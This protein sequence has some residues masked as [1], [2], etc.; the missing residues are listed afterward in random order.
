[1]IKVKITRNGQL[2]R[3]FSLRGHS[4]YLPRG[5]DIVCSAVSALSQTAVLALAQ[6]AGV[7]PVWTR[8]DGVLECKLPDDLDCLQTEASQTVLATI[9]LGIENIAQQ[10]P[11]HV[12]IST[13]EV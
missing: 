7:T 10:Y 13:E 6:V 2:I 1:M 8:Q 3:G 12:N 4:D 9:I 5:S 11:R